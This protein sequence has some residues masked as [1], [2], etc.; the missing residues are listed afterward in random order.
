MQSWTVTQ[1]FVSFVLVVSWYSFLEL[2]KYEIVSTF[3]LINVSTLKMTI[4]HCSNCTFFLKFQILHKNASNSFK[5]LINKDNKMALILSFKY[6][7]YNDKFTSRW[8]KKDKNIFAFRNFLV[9]CYYTSFIG[10]KDKWIQDLNFNIMSS[11]SGFY[12]NHLIN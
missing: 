4:S 7:D 3:F 12:C 11:S 6:F 9:K 8:Y 5:D 10:L 1:L 2:L